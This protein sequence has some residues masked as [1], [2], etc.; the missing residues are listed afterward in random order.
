MTPAMF[1]MPSSEMALQG[2]LENLHTL[3]FEP[4]SETRITETWCDTFDW[5]LV[6]A[7]QLLCLSGQQLGL[8]ATTTLSDMKASLS[9]ETQPSFAW[10]CPPSELRDQLSRLIAMRA[11]LPVHRVERY[12]RHFHMLDGERKT[13]A[14]LRLITLRRKRI[15]LAAPFF[16]ARHPIAAADSPFATLVCFEP[17]KGYEADFQKVLDQASPHVVKADQRDNLSDSLRA[18]GLQPLSYQSKPTLAFEAQQPAKSAPAMVLRASLSVIRRNLCGLR[19]DTDTEFLHDFRVASRRTR[20][21]I[22]QLKGAL[23]TDLTETIKADFKWLGNQTNRLR[24]L[25]VYLLGRD[26]YLAKVPAELQ[27]P[28]RIFFDDLAQQREAALHDVREA[29][30]S[31]HF[32]QILDKWSAFA[33]QEPTTMPAGPKGDQPLAK[34]AHRIVAKRYRRICRDGRRLGAHSPD[35]DLHDLRLQCKKLRYALELF[36]RLFDANAVKVAVKDLKRLQT[37]LGDFNDYSVQQMTL[38]EQAQQLKCPAR[39]LRKTMLAMGFLVAVL[40]Q[41]QKACRQQCLKAVDR[42]IGHKTQAHFDHLLASLVV[43]P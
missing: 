28:L 9:C 30:N 8:L 1:W 33:D 40:H 35:D 42:F 29:I 27:Q 37:K 20:A 11:I 22:S 15:Q 38:S 7:G 13:R 18:T 3:G 4:A 23:P 25:D 10:D 32:R 6:R 14:R 34:V 12:T 17:L 2:L 26:D 24:D 16:E 41:Q 19:A 36:E 31:D 43:S 39:S 21:A 5:R